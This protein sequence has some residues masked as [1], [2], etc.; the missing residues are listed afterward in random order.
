LISVVINTAAAAP[1]AKHVLSSG[2]VPYS[3]RAF[4]LQN[5]ILPA[6][7]QAS[8]IDEVIVAGVW[9]PAPNDEYK[10]VHV[11]PEHFSWADCIMQRQAGY[12]VASGDWIIH[13]HDDHLIDL[14][15]M[16]DI[17]WSKDYLMDVLSFNRITFARS[18]AGEEL[19]SGKVDGYVDGHC[20]AYK[21]KVLEACPWSAVPKQFT[22]DQLHTKQILDA[23]FHV[24][25]DEPLW[26]Q[27][28]EYG[29]QPWL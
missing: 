11:E 26:V 14:A 1:H 4:L 16:N 10:Y 19:N 5:I 23:G 12:N 9:K 6:Y 15:T 18:V 25:W 28:C 24:A 22:M 27:D 21:R 20:A 8:E 2:K 3:W 29:A 13:Q 7:T 17:A